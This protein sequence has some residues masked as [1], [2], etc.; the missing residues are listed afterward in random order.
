M[1]TTTF[2]TFKFVERLEKAGL[3][4]E[5]AAAIAEAQK[6]SL[7]EALDSTLATKT[8]IIRL[9][10]RLETMELRLTIKLGAFMAVSV[11]LVAAIIKLM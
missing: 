8:D 4:R 11:G 1:S 3:S 5:Q 7:S 9:E 2:D 10:N 6:D